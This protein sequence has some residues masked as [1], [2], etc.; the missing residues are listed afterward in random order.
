M[1][2]S[3]D[4][5]NSDEETTRSA[6]IKYLRTSCGLPQLGNAQKFTH[7]YEQA[8]LSFVVAHAQKYLYELSNAGMRCSSYN[9][10]V[11]V[12]GERYLLSIS[13]EPR[14]HLDLFFT[15]LSL[16]PL[17]AEKMVEVSAELNQPCRFRRLWVVAPSAL[18]SYADA[19][20]TRCKFLLDVA[21]AWA[22]E[23]IIAMVDRDQVRVAEGLY[24]LSREIFPE[25]SIREEL[26]FATVGPLYGSR[27]ITPEVARSALKTLSDTTLELPVDPIDMLAELLA[28]CLPRDLL[29]MDK[30]ARVDQSIEVNIRDAG[31]SKGI[32]RYPFVLKSLYRGSSLTMTPLL[33]ADKFAVL[34]LFPAGHTVIKERLAAHEQEFAARARELSREIVEA[35]SLF[36]VTDT[37]DAPNRAANSKKNVAHLLGESLDQIA[38]ERG[39]TG[40]RW[41]HLRFGGGNSGVKLN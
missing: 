21:S 37:E 13:E 20:A 32:S 4:F 41:R 10:L 16:T 1:V 22:A 6:L 9:E 7:A 23:R 31:Y 39:D 11:S 12:S 29:L 30:A 3:L 15:C 8:S 33:R 17:P 38:A 36:E 5:G 2:E 40:H 25:D 26:W 24:A 28:S 27:F 35:S 34:A 18:E 14:R 19:L